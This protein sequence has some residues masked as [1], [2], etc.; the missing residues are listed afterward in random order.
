MGSVYQ[1]GPKWW[2]KWRDASGT[3]QRRSTTAR[4][5]GEAQGLLREVEGAVQ[6]V[7]LGLQ[8]RPAKS[9]LS[10]GQLLTWYLAERCP[11]A[12]RAVA[13]ASIR[14]HVGG[15]ELAGYPASILSADHVEA[16][17]L[18]PMAAKGCAPATINRVRGILRAAFSA[19]SQP[20]RRFVGP[21]PIADTRLRPIERVERPTLSPDQVEALLVELAASPWAG[22]VATAAY[23]GLRRGEIF[24]LRRG[25]YDAASQ[26]LRVAGSHQ[27]RVTKSGRIDT[28][29]VPAALRPYLDAALEAGADAAVP[30]LWLFPRPDGRQRTRESDPHLVVRR[31]LVR[32]GIASSWETYCLT[33]ERAGRPNVVKHTGT[34]KPPAARCRADGRKLRVRADPLRFRFHDLRHTCASNLLRAGVPLVVVSRILRHSGIAITAN[35]YGHLEVEDL[36]QALNTIPRI[37]KQPPAVRHKAGTTPEE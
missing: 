3:M 12:S 17:V 28:L 23:L 5:K 29:P 27:R 9:K 20:P 1:R 7:T 30:S 19:A 10:V 34:E 36:R 18:E 32:L 37:T 31:A 22:V 24:A 4:T 16:Q 6:R 2:L 35:T 11:E 21:N 15:T 33:C 13:R 8:P 25:D 14:K 26:T